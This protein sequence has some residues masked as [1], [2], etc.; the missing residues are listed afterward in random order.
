MDTGTAAAKK[1]LNVQMVKVMMADFLRHQSQNL[2][3]A[4]MI[5]P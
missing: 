5:G 1:Q 2:T 3:L 4:E